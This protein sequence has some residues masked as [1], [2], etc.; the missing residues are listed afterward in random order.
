MEFRTTPAHFENRP[1]RPKQRHTGSESEI[2]AMKTRNFCTVGGHFSCMKKRQNTSFSKENSEPGTSAGPLR[3][4]RRPHA[5]GVMRNWPGS[6]SS[7]VPTRQPG[8]N[9]GRHRFMGPPH[10]I[11]WIWPSSSSSMAPTCQPRTR[12]GQLRCMKHLKGVV[13]IC[14][15]FSSSM[16]L[17]RQPPGRMR[18]QIRCMRYTQRV[19]WSG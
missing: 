3:C 1:A 4:I 2:A 11:V 14:R 12:R 18:S 6:S 8:T 19:M 10:G 7:M 17:S 9:A 5:S 13:R 16:V 15:I